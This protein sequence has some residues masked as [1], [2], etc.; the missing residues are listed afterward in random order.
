MCPFE[1]CPLE[2]Q[3][4]VLLLGAFFR[5]TQ[6]PKQLQTRHCTSMGLQQY[7]IQCRTHSVPVRNGPIELIKHSVSKKEESSFPNLVHDLYHVQTA[8]LCMKRRQCADHFNKSLCQ[9]MNVAWFS[10]QC[11]LQCRRYCIMIQKLQGNTR[12]VS[13]HLQHKTH[14]CG[15]PWFKS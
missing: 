11:N 8:D 7:T 1:A 9:V 4:P 15:F 3:P 13:L 5:T 2:M 12:R 10:S 14:T 6:R